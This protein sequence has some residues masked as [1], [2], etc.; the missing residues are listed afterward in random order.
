MIDAAKQM[1][2][3]YE[4][5]YSSTIDLQNRVKGTGFSFLNMDCEELEVEVNRPKAKKI[6]DRCLSNLRELV[7]QKILSHVIDFF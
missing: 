1:K 7:P 3:F 4:Q 6:I 5:T 2:D